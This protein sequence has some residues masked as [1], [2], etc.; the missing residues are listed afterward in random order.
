ML[1][2]LLFDCFLELSMKFVFHISEKERNPT[3]VFAR[4]VTCM[5]KFQLAKYNI[6]DSPI[7]S[8]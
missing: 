4:H 3:F 6:F 2:S 5:A 8:I 7:I 1:S